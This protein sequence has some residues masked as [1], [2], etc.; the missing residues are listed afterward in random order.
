[1]H[2]MALIL[3]LN[4]S[5]THEHTHTHTHTHTERE[6]SKSR[7]SGS[8]GVRWDADLPQCGSPT[9]PKLPVCVFECIH[10]R[11]CIQTDSWG[12]PL[13]ICDLGGRVVCVC[14]G[15][16]L[17]QR[18]HRVQG[19]WNFSYRQLSLSPVRPQCQESHVIHRGS[20]G[21]TKNV[22]LRGR[23]FVLTELLSVWANTQGVYPCLFVCEPYLKTFG[24]CYS[25]LFLMST[26]VTKSLKTNNVCLSR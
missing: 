21:A 24:W 26:K 12:S 1:M 5:H 25:L 11:S 10:M 13:P 8:E 20:L 4:A 22:G 9:S 19:V 17:L 3:I 23:I 18:G 6:P 14:G 2:A 7:P 16:T 15:S